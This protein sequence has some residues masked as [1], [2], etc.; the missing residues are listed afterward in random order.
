[1]VTNGGE[2]PRVFEGLQYQSGF[3]NEF[4]SEAIPGALP[5]GQNNPQVCPFGLYAEQLSGSAFTAPRAHNERTWLYRILPSV[6]HEPFQRVEASWRV[7]THFQSSQPTPNQLRWAPLDLPAAGEE[8]DF[9]AGIVSFCGAGSPSTKDGFAIHMY[10]ANVGMHRSCLANAD[11]SYLVVPQQGTLHLTTEMGLLEVPVGCIAVIPRGVR[12]SVDLPDGASRGYLLE[13][14][15]GSFRLP[16][17]GPIGANGLANARDFES[18]LAW[19]E[20]AEGDADFFTVLHKFEG[21]LFEAKQ[22]FSPFNVVAWHGN[23][24]PYRYNLDRFCPMNA[25]RF[26]HPDPSIFTVLTCPSPV[27]RTLHTHFPRQTLDSKQPRCAVTSFGR[28]LPRLRSLL[29]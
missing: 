2:R 3:G 26:D 6:T 17:L 18:P 9:V 29:R 20:D 15:A 27:A 21:E 8:V 16:D 7:V 12:F 11:G 28:W 13:V 23:Y 22:S 10:S 5:K 1:M 19:Y 25:V 4:Q 24:V 14:Y